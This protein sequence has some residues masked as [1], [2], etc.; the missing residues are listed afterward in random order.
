MNVTLM[1]AVV[2]HILLST[3]L[4]TAAAPAPVA[5]NSNSRPAHTSAHSNGPAIRLDRQD[6]TIAV[7]LLPDAPNAALIVGRDD[8]SDDATGGDH[9][10]NAQEAGGGSRRS[11]S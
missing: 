1:L 2:I 3:L 11:R 6:L 8:A 7:G 10:W 5:D 9:D 4:L